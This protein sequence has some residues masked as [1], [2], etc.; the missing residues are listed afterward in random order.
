[1][2]FFLTKGSLSQLYEI[3]NRHMGEVIWHFSC[4]GRSQTITQKYCKV[5]EH[6]SG[7]LAFSPMLILFNEIIKWSSESRN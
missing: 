1:M 2:T 6:L 4:D 7:Y 5:T 3:C